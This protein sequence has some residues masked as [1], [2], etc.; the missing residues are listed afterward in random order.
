MV[1]G[2][3]AAAKAGVAG[4]ANN[5]APDG[6][7]PDDDDEHNVG[8]PPPAQHHDDPADGDWGSS[9]VCSLYDFSNTSISDLFLFDYSSFACSFPGTL[10]MFY[11]SDLSSLLLLMYFLPLSKRKHFLYHEVFSFFLIFEICSI[12]YATPRSSLAD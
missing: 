3:K 8:G 11:K 9:Q 7:D 10:Q 4:F 5:P 12:Y 6:V 1:R 2:A